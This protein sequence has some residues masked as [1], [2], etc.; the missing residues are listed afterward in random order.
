MQRDLE[1]HTLLLPC[2]AVLNCVWLFA[3]SWTEAHQPPPPMEFSSQEYW[4]GLPFPTPGDLPSPGLKP[5]SLA[6]P[7]L[8]GS[9]FTTD[10]PGKMEL[11]MLLQVFSHCRRMCP[12]LCLTPWHKRELFQLF[13]TSFLYLFN[14]IACVFHG[15][16]IHKSLYSKFI[17]N[18]QPRQTLYLW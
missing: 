7:V 6:S 15:V 13:N 5:A 11:Y 3:V 17:S 18:K 4:N 2:C 10:L 8:L 16:I 1:L 12:G 14:Y 9:F